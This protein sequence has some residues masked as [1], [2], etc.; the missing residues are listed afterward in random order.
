VTP[1]VPPDDLGL[2]AG[3]VRVACH[4]EIDGPSGLGINMATPDGRAGWADVEL[5]IS[6]IYAHANNCTTAD[7]GLADD[8]GIAVHPSIDSR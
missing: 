3:L 8:A 5:A 6:W 1:R 7:H 2:R 4:A